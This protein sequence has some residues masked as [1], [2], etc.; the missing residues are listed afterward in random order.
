MA[1]NWP[2]QMRPA[3]FRGVR[4]YV[5]NESYKGGRRLKVH[6]FVDRDDP[7]IEDLGEAA[8][9]WTVKAFVS[10]ENWQ[11]E[12]DALF[13][14]ATAGGPATLRL[15]SRGGVLAH[16]SSVTSNFERNKLGWYGVDLEFNLVGEASGFTPVR[17]AQ[18]LIREA[19]DAALS[20]VVAA[21]V[22][23]TQ[24]VELGGQRPLAAE[25]FSDFVGMVAE[26][27]ESLELDDIDGP[28][29]KRKLDRLAEDVAS[30]SENYAVAKSWDESENVVL[31]GTGLF[32][33]TG[34]V[35]LEAIENATVDESTALRM[36]TMF[37]AMLHETP[38]ALESTQD[39]IDLIYFDNVQEAA[40]ITR[41]RTATRFKEDEDAH[42]LASGVRNLAL[43]AYCKV[44]SKLDFVTRKD[45]IQYRANLSGMLQEVAR[46]T[47]DAEALA[48]INAVVAKAVEY[49]SQNIVDL[50]PIVTVETKTSLPAVFWSYYLYG[51]TDSVEDLVERNGVEHPSF[52]P[53]EFE[54]VSA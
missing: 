16:C 8:K 3:S 6:E 28:Q 18:V 40:I 33:R 23:G 13:A 37:D 34:L 43:M 32:E 51:H 54:A 48:Q 30:L 29:I 53:P 27:P 22:N 17:L 35:L 52:M 12:M 25:A 45:A 10:S 21:V 26:L 36:A 47:V 7:V 38:R 50:K 11:S 49:I 19:A 24:G 46:E 41:R 44:I 31:D 5:D 1:T 20:A 14:A 2:D 9:T 15:P 4:F 39:E 42:V